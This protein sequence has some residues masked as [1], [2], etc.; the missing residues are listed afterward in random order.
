MKHRQPAASQLN[1]RFHIGFLLDD[2]VREP[3]KQSQKYTY[4]KCCPTKY[5]QQYTPSRV[6]SL[7]NEKCHYDDREEGFGNAPPCAHLLSDVQ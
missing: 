2:A 5:E 7:P 6:Q 1:I 3:I 4:S